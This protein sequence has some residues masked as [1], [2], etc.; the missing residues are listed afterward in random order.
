[1]KTLIRGLA[2]NYPVKVFATGLVVLVLLSLPLFWI[3][4]TCETSLFYR[5]SNEAKGV[6]IRPSG[7]VPDELEND[8]NVVSPSRASASIR[9]QR[10]MSL[11]IFD[12]FIAR[13]PGGR[14][15]NVYFFKSFREWMYFDIKTGQ[16]VH[17]YLEE[18]VMPDKTPFR[19]KVQRYIGPEGVSETA[20]KTLGRF[21][22]PLVDHGWTDV[23]QRQSRELIIFDKKLRC[24]FKT[25]FN[26]RTTTKGPKIGK[27]APIQKPIKIGRLS[28]NL[29]LFED[30]LFWIPPK[31]KSSDKNQSIKLIPIIPTYLSHDAG[32]YL[33]VLDESGEIGLLDKE[34]LT[35]A[36]VSGRLPAPET[37][38]GSKS[39]VRPRDLLDYQVMP[40]F[41]TT[42]SF[43]NPEEVRMTF[44]DMSAF[45]KRKA[46][47]VE[48]KYLGMFATGVSRDG[49]ALVLTVF[50]EKGK[51]IKSEYTKLHK[52]EGL[53]TTPVNSGR[54]VFFEPPWASTLTIGKYLAENL[55]PPILSIASYFTASAIEADAG[56]RALF[57]LPNSFI[58]MKG[59]ERPVNFAERFFSALWLILP[60]IILAILLS[61]RVS[62]DAVVVGLSENARLYWIIGTL[63]F[64]L[65]AYITYKLTRPKIAL[66][67]CQ[68]CGKPRRPDMAKCPRCGSKWNI[69]EL[70]PPTWRVLG[71]EELIQ[72]SSPAEETA[73]E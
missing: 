7:L 28:K 52:Q 29:L 10:P 24:F 56:H 50:D 54:A 47:R 63:A 68:N 73:T 2:L 12:Y 35:I 1:M 38:F 27:E 30:H 17:S 22:D 21:I 42:Y 16:L 60:S 61:I 39:A 53:R 62:K 57:F 14:R 8:P 48:K 4:F 20:D 45:F 43:E 36:G 31:I 19:K 71:G 41:L 3:R 59:R 55:H 49:S 11:G 23:R 58:A 40:L 5:M 26:Q 9:Y 6:S 67:T 15:S 13:L 18:Q 70:T 46:S 64:G 32:S 72:D 66:V 69:P 33:L 65:T 44:G 51:D 37:Y 25:D 34:S